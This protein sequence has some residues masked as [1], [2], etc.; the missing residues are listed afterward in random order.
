MNSASELVI[1]GAM[2]EG[3]G[4]VLRCCLSLAWLQQ[5][6]LRVHSIRAGRPKPGL[7]NQHLAGVRVRTVRIEPAKTFGT[8]S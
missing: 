7:A 2:L 6:P 8:L 3:G 5:S 1:D 4:Q